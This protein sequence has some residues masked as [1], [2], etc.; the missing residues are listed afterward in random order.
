MRAYKVA[1]LV[2]GMI[3]VPP[4]P[5]VHAQARASV[6]QGSPS[7]AVD[8]LI[9]RFERE[10]TGAAYLM[11]AARYDF[12]PASLMVPGANFVGVRSFADQV[13]HVAQ[14]NY[15]VAANVAGSAEAVDVTSIGRLRT[16]P[17]ILVALAASFLAVHKAVATITAG[18]Q[19]DLIEDS[20]VAPNQTRL[21]EA[22]W[23]AVHGYD[24]YGQLVEYLRLNGF[25][26]K[27]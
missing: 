4:L 15:S 16:K 10:F 18:N 27:P 20:G 23:V 1:V 13:R 21:S 12:T 22:A 3:I 2:A 11:P 8:E 19:D 24:H 25:A 17:E 9:S 6:R 7:R 5:A 26:P 14:A